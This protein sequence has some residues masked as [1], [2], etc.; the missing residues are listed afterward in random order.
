MAG[1][2]TPV[3]V[4]AALDSDRPHGTTVSAFMSLSLEPPMVMVALDS[5]SNLL[6]VIRAAGRFSIN[7]LG[8]SQAAWARTFA[9]KEVDDRFAEVKWTVRSSVP[10]L[11]GTRGWLACTVHDAVGAGDHIAILA[12]VD[13]T[14]VGDTD[15][16]TYYARA[17]GT[18]RPLDRC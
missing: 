13:D 14:A 18:H 10:Q 2:A 9:D 15:P 4:V 11:S 3:A 16:L 5:A 8:A 6:P 12:S 1:V 7:I 17:F